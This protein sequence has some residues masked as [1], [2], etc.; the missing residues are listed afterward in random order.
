MIP[1]NRSS[2]S[3]NETDYVNDAIRRGRL[4]AGGY[5]NR[6]C[7][8]HIQ[9]H[10]KSNKVLLTSSCSSALEIA[11]LLLDLQPGDEVIV[12]SFTFVTTASAFALH[13]AKIVFADIDPKTLNINKE[14]IEKLITPKTKAIVA[15]HYAGIACKMDELTEIAQNHQLLLIEDAALGY[16]AYYKSRALGTIGDVGTFSFHDTKNICCGE[17]GAISINNP[18]LFERAQI[19]R[20]KGTNR[21]NFENNQT[22]KYE[23]VD[24]GSSYVMSELN[25][26]FLLGQLEKTKEITIAR[27]KIWERYKNELSHLELSGKAHLPFVPGNTSLNGSMFYMLC[28]DNDER[29]DLIKHLRQNGIVGVFHYLPLHTSPFFS[30]LHKGGDLNISV[31]YSNSIIRLPL[32]NTLSY[33]D[34]SKVIE[35]IVSFYN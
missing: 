4:S 28:A 30:K 19:I 17:G 14:E 23:C 13:G 16:D 25:A 15:V 22:D 2:V 33:S 8:D 7:E 9:K 21:Q 6:K 3:G 32:Y 24:L 20:D 35:A 18:K 5:Y 27:I 29:N 10:I 12:P 26:A 1:F 11:A 31:N 34:Q